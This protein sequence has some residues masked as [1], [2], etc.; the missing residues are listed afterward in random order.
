LAERGISG[1]QIPSQSA[2]KMI[3]GTYFIYMI[4]P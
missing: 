1:L 2:Q 3:D 4:E